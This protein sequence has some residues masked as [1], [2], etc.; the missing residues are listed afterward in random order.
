MTDLTL[1]TPKLTNYQPFNCDAVLSVEVI[2]QSEM[3]LAGLL[4]G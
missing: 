3:N 2:K 1:K 4:I